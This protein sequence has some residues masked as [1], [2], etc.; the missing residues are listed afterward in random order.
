MPPG[1]G[2]A[3]VVRAGLPRRDVLASGARGALS[4]AHSFLGAQLFPL[5]LVRGSCD[6]FEWFTEH[7][8]EQRMMVQ[9]TE[10]AE[11]TVERRLLEPGPRL[12]CLCHR[13]VLA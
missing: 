9:T 5:G 10:A 12:S 1:V 7:P 4:E 11:A 6:S 2:V 3:G 13:L 8:V